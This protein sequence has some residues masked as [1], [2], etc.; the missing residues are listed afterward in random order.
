MRQ[1]ASPPEHRLGANNIDPLHILEICCQIQRRLQ[2]GTDVVIRALWSWAMP[3]KSTPNLEFLKI[4]EHS[5]LPKRNE[6]PFFFV[7]RLALVLRHSMDE[8]C[9]NAIL[10]LKEKYRPSVLRPNCPC[11]GCFGCTKIIFTWSS[12]KKFHN[13]AGEIRICRG[14]KYIVVGIFLVFCEWHDGEKMEKILN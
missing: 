9:T 13:T 2:R 6:T 14:D 5:R 10:T 11:F 12:L 8:G 4:F 3:K 1:P 7:Q